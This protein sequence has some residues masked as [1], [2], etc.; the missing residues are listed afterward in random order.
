MKP[1]GRLAATLE[2]LQTTSDSRWP[3]DGTI[4]DYMRSRR[5]IGSKDRAAI[6]E[7]TYDIVR[8]QARLTWHL[9]RNH[10]EVNPRNLLIAHL[11]VV[12]GLDVTALEALFDGA[13]YAPTPLS[14]DEKKLA[15]KLKG[16]TLEAPS[17]PDVVR[18]E[19]P[20]QHETTLKEFFGDAFETEMKAFISS[21][22][23]DLRVNI[24]TISRNDAKESLELNK[25]A[26][27]ETP[28]S[29]WG[30]RAR[31]KAYL[32]ETKAFR[33]GHIEIQDEGS[34]LIAVLCDAKP[35]QQVLDYC[36]GSGGKTLALASAMNVK[37]RI[38]A[39]DT[40]ENRLKKARER[41]RRAHAHDIIEVRPLSDEK[42]RKW[43]RRQKETFD[44]ALADVPCSGTGTWRRNPDLRW[45]Q[46]GPTL[47]ALLQTQVE[48][49]DKVAKTVKVGGRLVY[50]TCSLLPQ[51]NEK[52]IEAFLSRHPEFTLAPLP[53]N[54][55]GPGPYMR[56]TPLRHKTDGFFGAV[57][58]RTTTS[59]ATSES[60]QED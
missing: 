6:V 21:A 23:L 46:F 27:D 1:S 19:C 48:I 54:I 58:T 12:E 20:P 53:A 41:F 18:A 14:D 4:G 29:P 36:A 37:G 39:M 15:T 22:P 49:L 5:Y 30:L 9:D 44:I 3:M 34:Q 10:A 17:M 45:R 57:L 28:F 32:S 43:L 7:R 24:K 60:D 26:T 51:E 31:G 8:A 13:Q 16:A 50:A 11:V 40:E 55:P 52:Q 47:D 25:V 42:N 33:K 2:I 59:K 56:L 38:V 35:G